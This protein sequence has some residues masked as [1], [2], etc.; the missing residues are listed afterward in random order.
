MIDLI[1]LIKET[2]PNAEDKTCKEKNVKINLGLELKTNSVILKTDNCESIK[3]KQKEVE[4][5]KKCDCIIISTYKNVVYLNI[6][7][8]KTRTGIEDRFEDR[9]INCFNVFNEWFS[10]SFSGIKYKFQLK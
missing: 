6:I 9:F 7:E 3:N 2:F 4:G 10:D 8:L 5:Y 1:S